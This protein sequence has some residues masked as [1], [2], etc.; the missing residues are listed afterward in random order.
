MSKVNASPI[1]GANIAYISKG[2]TVLVVEDNQSS[3]TVHRTSV[4]R[5]KTLDRD[6]HTTYEMLKTAQADIV[7]RIWLC[8]VLNGYDLA[9]IAK[10]F[11]QLKVLITSGYASDVV[12]I[13][14]PMK[15]LLTFYTNRIGG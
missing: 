13:P 15:R 7:F 2:E 14:S 4:F 6:Q 9:K 12:T 1:S 10:E 5:F 3:Q 8:G 11:P